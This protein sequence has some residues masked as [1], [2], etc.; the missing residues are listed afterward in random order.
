MKSIR[1]LLANGATM[2]TPRFRTRIGLRVSATVGVDYACA[3]LIII[4]LSPRRTIDRE[5][6]FR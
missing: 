2:T 6:A 5:S 3:T 4:G 1:G